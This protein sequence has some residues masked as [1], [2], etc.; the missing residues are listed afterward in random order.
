MT[1]ING[2]KAQGRQEAYSSLAAISAEWPK[3]SRH[4]HDINVIHDSIQLSR[5]K[6][7]LNFVRCSWRCHEALLFALIGWF[8]CP[9]AHVAQPVPQSNMRLVIKQTRLCSQALWVVKPKRLPAASTFSFLTSGEDLTVT[10][11]GKG[12]Y[13]ISS[14]HRAAHPDDSRIIHVAQKF[15]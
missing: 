13:P 12:A 7:Q 8:S 15:G 2:P 6:A 14:R 1:Q 3:K 10:V 9:R 5:S 11:N 4:Q